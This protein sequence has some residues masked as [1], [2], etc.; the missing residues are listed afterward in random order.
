MQGLAVLFIPV[1]LMFLAMG[2]DRIERVLCF[3]PTAKSPAGDEGAADKRTVAGSL[4][5][6]ENR[7]ASPGSDG[8][9]SSAA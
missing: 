4:R 9:R 3:G 1:L 2:L 8:L 6:Q 7:A 5:A